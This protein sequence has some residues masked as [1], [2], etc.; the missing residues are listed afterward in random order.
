MD[1]VIKASKAACFEISEVKYILNKK[2][3][4][5]VYKDQQFTTDVSDN[6]FS[7][8]FS[9]GGKRIIPVYVEPISPREIDTREQSMIMA[10][11][12]NLG[13][14][15]QSRAGLTPRREDTSPRN[16]HA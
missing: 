4:S 12:R 10:P 5:A 1:W 7:Q 13:T 8:D 11:F 15:T 16:Q 9:E 14:E 3:R 6:Y 2:K